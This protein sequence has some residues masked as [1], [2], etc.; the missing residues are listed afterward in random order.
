VRQKV[1]DSGPPGRG[2]RHPALGQGRPGHRSASTPPACCRHGLDDQRSA[3][4]LALCD[5]IGHGGPYDG[6]AVAGRLLRLLD[7]LTGQP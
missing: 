7:S 6:E 1:V 5:D 3:L 2:T 4:L